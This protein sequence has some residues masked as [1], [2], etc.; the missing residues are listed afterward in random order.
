MIKIIKPPKIT[1]KL[2]ITLM[3]LLNVQHTN[4]QSLQLFNYVEN[5]QLNEKQ[6]HFANAWIK[7]E[8]V[9]SFR[10]I[11]I[12]QTSFKGNLLS[13]NLPG[14]N[15]LF[16]RQKE[17]NEHNAGLYSW[18]G[19]F[20]NS[21]GNAD[22]V[23]NKEMIT[24][25]I[26]S[27]NYVYLIYP[28]TNGFHVLL[29]C[30]QSAMPLDESP[31]AYRQMLE[32]G[33]KNAA[34]KQ[35]VHIDP[36]VQNGKE[37]KVLAGNC[38]VRIL[39][40]FDDQAA[41][42]MADPIGFINS[43]IDV[44]NTCYSNS[45][46]SFRAELAVA[47]QETYPESLNS[48]TDKTRFHDNG[49]GFLDNVFDLRT[50]F[51]ADMCVLIVENLQSGICGEAYTVANSSYTD[52]F[53]VV[54]RGCSVGNL[55]FPHEL[56][57]LYGCRH[58]TYVD[59]ASTPYAFGHGYINLPNRWRTVMA[60]NDLCAA[61]A[62]GTACTRIA[63]FSNPNVNYGGLATGVANST[64]NKSALELSR[65]N[66]SS[67][68]STIADKI[69]FNPYSFSGGEQS[70]VIAFNSVTNNTSFAYQNGSNGSWRAGNAVVMSPGFIAHEGSTF[71]AY[72]DACNTLKPGPATVAKEV[73]KTPFLKDE[74]NTKTI[75]VQPNP[76]VSKFQIIIYSTTEGKAHLNI[77]NTL[78][79][80]LKELYNINIT[81]G[82]NKIE[83]D[84]KGFSPGMYLV[85]SIIGHNKS[86]V[87]LIKM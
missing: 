59:N 81:K 48:A 15:N 69:F 78:G 20:E 35:V 2:V 26:S 1:I 14:N 53:C 32:E 12:D 4:G 80:K 72:L 85:E 60:Y 29:E 10:Y 41:G 70:D 25:R 87:K 75:Q 9:K 19:V 62:P 76:F 63:Y 28:L 18:K 39:V 86:T 58:D 6:I 40:M 37:E 83:I 52:P 66:I 77:Y 27:I 5:P 50:Y 67:L 8:W 21:L 43:C 71:R 36:E 16:V 55:S 42:N 56:G 34:E 3:T 73:L 24:A 46:L 38:N 44:S 65:A 47:T 82:Q 31:Q 54:T 64:D 7:K 68:E 61:T 84:G 57:H 11:K 30:D 17:L 79:I 33:A 22:F 45:G 74:F 51:D 49:D 13:V 23:V